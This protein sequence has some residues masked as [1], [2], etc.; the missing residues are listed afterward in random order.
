MRELPIGGTMSCSRLLLIAV[1]A[2]AACGEVKSSP[3]DAAG[4]DGSVAPDATTCSEA[5]P[6]VG[7][8]FCLSGVCVECTQNSECPATAPICDPGAHECRVCAGHGECGSSVCDFDTGVCVP[9]ERTVYVATDGADGGG[10]GTLEAPCRT[11]AIAGG[12]LTAPRNRLRLL[13]GMYSEALAL[14]SSGTEWLVIAEGATLDGASLPVDATQIVTVGSG[15]GVVLDG[16]VVQN[17]PRDGIRCERGTLTLVRATIRNNGD[18]GVNA[19]ACEVHIAQSLFSFNTD[20]GVLSYATDQSNP[21]DAKLYVD[22]TRFDGN[23]GGGISFS[24]LLDVRNSVFVRTGVDYNSAIRASESIAGTVIAFNTF[25]SNVAGFVSIVVCGGQGVVSSNVFHRNETEFSG[26]D[27]LVDIGC[28]QVESNYADKALPESTTRPNVM[29]D[30]PG[31]VSLATDD[32][33]LVAGSP[34]ID[35]GDPAYASETD[36]D[37]NPR[38]AGAAPDIGAFERR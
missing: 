28:R 7:G 14:P 32:F 30:A 2:C 37:G 22:R 24:G 27:E 11:F 9:P 29:G 5:M 3:E 4:P 34:L 26:T 19:A 6:C 33:H 18:Y 16:A 8:G 31:F 23:Q 36:F 13:P 21:V 10:C 15:A 38:T 12:K 35:R 20:F 1:I 17:S 25:V